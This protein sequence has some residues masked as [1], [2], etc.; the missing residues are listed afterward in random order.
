MRGAVLALIMTA[1][2]VVSVTVRGQDPPVAN[3]ALVQSAAVERTAVSS[4]SVPF[5]SGNTAG[6][7]IVAFVRMSTATQ[8]VSVTDTAGNLYTDAVSQT[9]DTD[10]HQV[11][12]FY[13]KNVAGGLNTVTATF[14]SVNNHPW[15]AVYEYSGLSTTN[16]LDQTAHAQG[17]DNSPFTGLITTTSANELEFAAAGFPATSFTGTVAPG[18]G[19]T[20]EQQDTGTSR[21]ATEDAILS[22]TGQYAGR[23]SLSNSTSWSAVVATFVAAGPIAPSVT[24]SSLPDATQNSPYSATLSAT[25][26]T[27][28]YSWAIIGGTLP[29]GLTLA[30]S[31]GT[32]SGTPTQAATSTFTVQVTDANSQTATKALSITVNPAGGS[33]VTIAL[34]QAVGVERTAVAS[35]PAPFLSSN[36]AGNLLIVFVRMSSITQTVSVTDTAGNSYIDAVSQTQDTDGHQIHIF[37]AKNIA[38]GPNTVT[39]TFSSTNNHPWLAAF[40][41][42]GLSA[43]SPLSL[44][45]HAQGSIT[46]PTAA[47]SGSVGSSNYLVLAGAGFPASFSGTATAASG[48]MI[49]QDTG[50]SRASIESR[51]VVSCS[52]C[53]VTGEFTLSSSTNWSVAAAAFVAAGTAPLTI[54]T[55]AGTLRPGTQNTP[56][57]TQTLAATGGATPYTWSVVAGSLPPGLILDASSGS[58]TGTPTAT[59]TFNF[60]AQVTDANSQTATQNFSITIFPPVVITTTSFPDGTVGQFYSASIQTTGGFQPLSYFISSGSLPPGLTKF[61]SENNTISGTPTTAGTYNF[62]VQATD[63]SGSTD[64]KALS[65]TINPSAGGGGGIALVQSNAVERTAVSSVSATFPAGN[66]APN[67]IIAFVRMSTTTQTVTVTDS[68][69]NIYTDAISQTQDTD[70]HQ[71]HLFYAKNIAGGANTVTAT[72]SSI[73]NHPWLAVYE[74]RGLSTTSPLDVGAHAQGSDS[75]PFTGLITTTSANELEFAAAGF[76]ATAFTGTVSPGPGYTLEQQ[77]VGTSRAANADAILTTTGQFAGRFNLSTSTNWSAVVATFK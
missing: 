72:F 9:Q 12:I 76:P 74:Y 26:G 71:I 60:T 1:A 39:A 16:P 11:H 27:T 56:Y 25:G 41:Y 30:S 51:T 2:V 40:E 17:S 66:T 58:I 13:A 43:T 21:A 57:I 52:T 33:G 67:L 22:V 68:A 54:A 31:T 15:M 61:H 63:R 24:T 37:Y 38:G 3:F 47:N 36:T 48:S 5:P 23:F 77:D 65:I 8:T 10:G 62:T 50:T 49:L 46:T 7:L 55:Q 59:G 44:T 53:G 18:P 28:P 20:L 6:N 69:G 29:A 70:G 75:S 14:S 32:I 35:V 19:Y 64:T 34:V 42:S 4:V 73:N 45:A